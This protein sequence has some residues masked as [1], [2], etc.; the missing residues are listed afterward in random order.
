MSFLCFYLRIFPR[1]ELKLVIYSLLVFSVLYIIAFVFTTLFNCTPVSYIWTSW[2]G[3]HTG[4]CINFHIF[5]WVHAGI[6]IVFDIVVILVPIPELVRLS[7]S[8][9]KKVYIMMMFSIGA[10]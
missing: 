8:M 3:E 5:A 7:M 4:K 6:N 2:D 1:R 10:L 9:K